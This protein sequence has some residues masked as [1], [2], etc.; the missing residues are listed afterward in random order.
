MQIAGDDAGL[1][2]ANQIRAIDLL[3]LRQSVGP[4]EDAAGDFTIASNTCGS[5]V[6]A[7]TSC[8]VGLTFKPTATG[9]RLATLEVTYTGAGSPQTMLLLGTGT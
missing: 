2:D 7:G 9:T 1:D 3:D 5:S 6:A 8:T 4:E